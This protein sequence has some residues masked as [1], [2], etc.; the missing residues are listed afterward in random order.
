LRVHPQGRFLVPL[1]AG[2]V[3]TQG[4]IPVSKGIA[5]NKQTRAAV[6]AALL[7]GQGVAQIAAR[8]QIPSRTVWHW[9]SRQLAEVLREARARIEA[10]LLDYLAENLMTLRAQLKVA[11]NEQYLKKQTASELAALHGVLAD[12]AFKILEALGTAEEE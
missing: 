10:L 5:H 6:L 12:K 3:A 1:A 7:A 8:Y 2:K 4:G 9:R 11:G